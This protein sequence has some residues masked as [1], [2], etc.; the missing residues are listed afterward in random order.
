VPESAKANLGNGCLN[1]SGRASRDVPEPQSVNFNPARADAICIP[2][3]TPTVAN[4]AVPNVA[5]ISS[6]NDEFLVDVNVLPHVDVL[7]H[8]NILLHVDVLGHVSVLMDWFS[9]Y[10]CRDCEPQ[11]GKDGKNDENF[12]YHVAFSCV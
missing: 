3:A 8:V 2:M 11:R 10:R 9:I 5:I 4:R 1:F 12:S 6:S 7:L